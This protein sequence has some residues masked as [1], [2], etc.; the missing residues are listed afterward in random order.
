AQTHG[1]DWFDVFLSGMLVTEVLTHH[2]ETGHWRRPTI[3]MA[4]L[5]LAL[6]LMHGK[7]AAW[8]ARKRAL[9]ITSDT[10]SIG[11]RFWFLPGFSVKWADVTRVDVA[12]AAAV[13][14]TRDGRERRIALD[15]MRNP[16]P[17]AD[18][19]RTAATQQRKL[20]L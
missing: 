15:E 9:R 8:G 3:L 16:G 13:V 11:H 4:V 1:V 18:A 12:D 7:I 10:L 19:L 5:M 14:V 2:Y 17:V 20:E 6:G